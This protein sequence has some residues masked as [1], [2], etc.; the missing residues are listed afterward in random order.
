M[1][2]ST[3]ILG[4]VAA[5]ALLTACSDRPAVDEGVTAPPTQRQAS[6]SDTV[7]SRDFGTHVVHF[8][9]L[10]TSDL[11]PEVAKNFNIVRSPNQVM[12]NVSVTRKTESGLNEPARAQVRVAA[13]NLA[14]QN[15][16]LTL[17]EIRDG[18]AWYYIGVVPVINEET[19]IFNIEATPEG[20]TSPLDVQFKRQFFTN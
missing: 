16:G 5:G 13:R 9:A 8:N 14:N 7:A 20:A 10:R 12:L 11:T 1:R 19:L 6:E 3:R 17:R 2:M 4:A 18:E 15:K